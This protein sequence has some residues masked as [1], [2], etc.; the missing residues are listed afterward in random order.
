MVYR[1]QAKPREPIKVTKVVA[2][3]LARSAFSRAG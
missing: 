1:V 3:H 2:Y